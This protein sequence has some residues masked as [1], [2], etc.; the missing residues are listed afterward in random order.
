MFMSH[1]I[2]SEFINNERLINYKNYDLSAVTA[3]LHYFGSPHKSIKTVHIAGTNGKGSVAHMLA[4]IL[5][6]TGYKTGLYTSPHLLSIN[7]RIM[8]NDDVIDDHMLAM[9]SVEISRAAQKLSVTPT[10]FDALTISA[11]LYFNKVLCDVAVI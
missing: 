6:H 9:Y 10:Y 2:F 11:F 7:E 4:G 8:V 5:K 1:E 3:L